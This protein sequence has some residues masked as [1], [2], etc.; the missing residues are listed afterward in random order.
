MEICR[1]EVQILGLM[2]LLWKTI[3]WDLEVA[4]IPKSIR[5][6]PVLK[7]WQQSISL[8]GCLLGICLSRYDVS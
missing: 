8:D 2:W 3:G 4:R 7:I 1:R 6:C 5:S